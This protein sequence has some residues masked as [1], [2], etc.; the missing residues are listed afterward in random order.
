MITRSLDNS[1]FIFG[2]KD[3][4]GQETNHIY[5]LDYR[6]AVWTRIIPNSEVEPPS[7][8]SHNAVYYKDTLFVAGGMKGSY[9]FCDAWTFDFGSREW[10]Q[11]SLDAQ[12]CRGRSSYTAI[13]NIIYILGGIDQAYNIVDSLCAIN[14]IFRLF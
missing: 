3:E 2:G 1:I 13:D 5:K 7:R 6:N 11:V 10:S 12:L 14:V 8:H 9:V 4:S